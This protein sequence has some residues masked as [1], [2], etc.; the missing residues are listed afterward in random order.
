MKRRD[1]LATALLPLVASQVEAVQRPKRNPLGLVVHS[2]WLRSKKPMP[3]EFGDVTEPMNLLA[4]AERLGAAGIQTRLTPTTDPKALRAACER[5]GL[6]LE[7][8]IGLPRSEA[9][10]LRFEG[11]LRGLRTAGATIARTVC[12]NGRRYEAFTTS[13]QFATFAAEARRALRIA[14][15]AAARERVILAVEN[16]KDWR[17][18]ELL[19]ELK[20]VSSE[21]LR[22]CLDTGNSIALLEDP[23]TTAQQLAPWVVTTHLKDMATSEIEDGFLLA[24]VPFGAGRVDLPKIVRVLREANPRVRLNLEMITRDPLR[25]PCLTE[26]YWAT[27][28]TL[29]ARELAAILASMRRTKVKEPPIP[30]KLEPL[31]QLRLEAANIDECLRYAARHLG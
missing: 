8:S 26:K 17:T 20:A 2:Y 9:D 19:A 7:G 24:E 5:S 21:W 1:F 13:D 23:L 27:L 15:T 4:V 22:V 11:E 10:L 28:P 6:Y 25:V 29:P 3:P 31:A 30:S 12:M 18:E 16:H 14:V